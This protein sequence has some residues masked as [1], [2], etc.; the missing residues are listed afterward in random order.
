MILEVTSAVIMKLREDAS[1]AAP[2]ECCGLLLGRHGRIEQAQEAAN[3]A[4]DPRRR[5]EIDPAALFAAFKAARG[6]GAQV[7]G[8][9]HSHPTGDARPSATDREHSTGDLRIWAIIADSEVAFWRDNANG[10]AS[11]PFRIVQ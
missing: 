10:S 11:Q 5:F 8:Y 1:R 9:Y 2:E 4:P 3:I 7:L 6:E